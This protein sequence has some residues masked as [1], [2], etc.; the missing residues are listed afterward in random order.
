MS[1]T[2]VAPLTIDDAE[3]ALD[4][5]LLFLAAAVETLV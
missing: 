3:A 1:T 5:P 4:R 2:A